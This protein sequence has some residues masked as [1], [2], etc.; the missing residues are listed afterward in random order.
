[1]A[2]HKANLVITALLTAAGACLSCIIAQRQPEVSFSARLESLPMT[3]GAW[4][5]QDVRLDA[6]SRNALSADSSVY[7]VYTHT[8]TGRQVGLLVVYRR[9]GRREFAHRPELCY[10]AAGW[11]IAGE[12]YA[13]LP[14]AGRDVRARVVAAEKDGCREAVTYWFASGRRTEA[15]YVRQQA[16]M[17]LD[18][19]QPRKYGWAFIRLNA[20]EP[21]ALDL[22]RS[23]MRDLDKPLAAALSGRGASDATP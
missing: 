21:R 20:P 1:M 10:P 19:M 8:G 7:R 16:L 5:G 18:R 23:F 15:N 11:E 22:T 9:Y 14:Y 13:V 17:A 2:Q 12:S 4:H 3:I 6:A